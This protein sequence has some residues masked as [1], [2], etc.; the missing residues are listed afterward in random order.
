MVNRRAAVLW[1]ALAAECALLA[2]LNFFDDWTIEHTA[3]KFTAVAIGAGFTYLAAVGAFADWRG[4]QRALALI[5]WSGAV[6]FR[7]LALPLAPGDDLW[8]YQWEG[9][10]QRAGV[11]PYLHAPDDPELVPLRAKYSHWAAINHRDIRAVYPP[12]AQLIF[13]GLSAISERPLVYK[14]LFTVADLGV[15]WLL[16]R[17]IGGPNRYAQASWYAWNPLAI[18][19]FAGGAH[20]DSLMVLPFV[21][22]IYL[23][24]RVS[25][26][27]RAR[28]RW[29]LASAASLCLGISI[30]V[31][32]IPVLLLPLFAIALGGRAVTLLL[33]LAVPALASVPFG[34]PR[35][36]IWEPL[37]R[38]A[39]VTRTNDL[40]W[41]LIEETVW[42]NPHQMNYHYNAIILV[43]VAL[44]SVVFVRD[45]RRGMLWALG[46]ALIL[47]PAMHP[48]YCTWILPLAAW[49]RADAWSVLSVTLF[50]YFLFWDERLFALPWHA[51][52]WQRGI[53]LL[54]PLLAVVADYLRPASDTESVTR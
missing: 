24:V 31:K 54:P 3:T 33:S 40:F 15:V 39:H 12:G 17:L 7:L 22:A 8:R 6:A 43:V 53:I 44:L 20:F 18:Y 30:S 41:W 37:L 38:F 45:W 27:A 36:P 25:G 42:P 16:V 14:L 19:C 35:I 29:L 32:L 50:A 10:L 11:N 52:L 13:R 48:W 1:A 9:T 26:A 46:T 49:R 2:A 34:F 21:A 47:S 4:S 5:F 28:D 23:L 51:E